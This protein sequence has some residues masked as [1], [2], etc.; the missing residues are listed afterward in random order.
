MLSAVSFG[1]DGVVHVVGTNDADRIGAF[2]V[3]ERFVVT[4]NGA[5]RMFPNADVTGLE[6]RALAGD[7]KIDV[8]RSVLQPTIL[9]GNAGSDSI[10]GGSGRDII[11]GGRGDDRAGGNAGKDIIFGGLGSDGLSGGTGFDIIVGDPLL[12][13]AEDVPPLD[14][15]EVRD[16]V[17]FERFIAAASLAAADDVSVDVVIVEPVP[18]PTFDDTISGGADVDVIL[19][20]RGADTIKGNAGID[21]IVGGSGDDYIEGGNGD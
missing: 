13:D 15:P 19:G 20:M 1:D 18:A 21:V 3:A 2:V 12:S 5:A 8:K 4:L 6:V 14:R 17:D 16:A 10:S 9:Y 11:L 7:D